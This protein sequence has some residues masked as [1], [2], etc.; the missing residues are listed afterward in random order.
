M[1]A[2]SGED[3]MPGLPEPDAD[4]ERLRYL[5]YEGY[6]KQEPCELSTSEWSRRECMKDL[7]V[8]DTED[9]RRRMRDHTV[10]GN[11]SFVADEDAFEDLGDW[12]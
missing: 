4:V 3:D 8:H 12:K 5:W 1:N 2:K 9:D 7:L 11:T 6:E 10:D